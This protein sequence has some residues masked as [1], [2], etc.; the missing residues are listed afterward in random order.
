MFTILT[1][2]CFALNRKHS[3][4]ARFEFQVDPEELEALAGAPDAPAP[5]GE[6]LE[7]LTDWLDEA[8]LAA[9]RALTEN[10]RATLLLRALGQMRYHEMA[11]ALDMPL[12][13]VMGHLSRARHKMRAVLG[14]PTPSTRTPKPL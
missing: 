12:G 14:R 11:E 10:E 6:T 3:R 2:E 7:G 8:M 9:L 1:R 5:S 4:A 13:S